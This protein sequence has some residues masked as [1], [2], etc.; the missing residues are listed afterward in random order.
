MHNK[1]PAILQLQLLYICNYVYTSYTWVLAF[2]FL[3]TAR[4]L[5]IEALDV[6]S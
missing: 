5:T 4:H 3:L 2:V 6:Q 1:R